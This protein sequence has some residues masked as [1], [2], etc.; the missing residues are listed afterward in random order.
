MKHLFSR[1]WFITVW[2]LLFVC[3]F[4]WGLIGSLYYE[5]KEGYWAKALKPGTREYNY[6]HALD[7]LK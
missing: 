7:T 6:Y 4:I 2:F 1:I 3:V 5:R